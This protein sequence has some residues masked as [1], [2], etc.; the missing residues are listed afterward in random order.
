VSLTFTPSDPHK[1]GIDSNHNFAVCSG[2]GLSMPAR[3]PVPTFGCPGPT[4]VAT[5][6]TLTIG[7]ASQAP[8]APNPAPI[9]VYVASAGHRYVRD[10]SIVGSPIYD[11]YDC[12]LSIDH[13]S[14]FG[15]GTIATCLGGPTIPTPVAAVGTYGGI[16]AG[17]TGFWSTPTPTPETAAA[18]GPAPKTCPECDVETSTYLDAYHGKDRYLAKC[19]SRCRIRAEKRRV[20]NEVGY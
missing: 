12:G 3:N 5:R 9:G 19:C 17:Q 7:N 8:V 1:W 18:E 11:C 10:H 6:P 2:C 15:S 14:L 13:L 4:P 16:T 20:H